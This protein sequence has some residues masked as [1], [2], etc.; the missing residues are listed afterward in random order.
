MK[1]FAFLSCLQ[2]FAL[3]AQE[4]DPQAKKPVS[5]AHVASVNVDASQMGPPRPDT[6]IATINGKKLTYGEF[7]TMVR[8]LPQ[9][10]Q[11]N[12][13][14]N[15]KAFVNQFALMRKLADIAETSKL[16]QINPYKDALEFRREQRPLQQR[17]GESNL[18]T[19]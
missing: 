17:E 18:Y 3:L 9:Q 14:Q 8:S 15:R 6:V 11:Q 7:Q 13:M 16:D 5:P 1:P 4:P 2:V 10:M 19:V 12:A